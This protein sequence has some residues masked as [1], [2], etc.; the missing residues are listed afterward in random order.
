MGNEEEFRS[1]VI[2]EVA[3][4]A[5]ALLGTRQQIQPFSSQFPTFDLA[6]AYDV[7]ERIRTARM[8]RGEKPAGRKIGFTNRAT[9]ASF[10]I[11]A[12]IWGYVYDS[13][14]ADL[15]DNAASFSVAALPEAR[16]EPEIVLHLAR[17]PQLGMNER[18]LFGCIDWIAHGFEIVCSI[19]P[20]WRF[21]AA[22]AVA[23]FGMHSA[24]L[25][26]TRHEIARNR[27]VLLDSL[28]NFTIE[29]AGNSGTRRGH[30]QGILGGPLSA[31]RA[32]VDV[33]A[34]YPNSIPLEAGEVVTTGA[35]TEPMPLVA[36]EV[37]STQVFGIDLKGLRLLVE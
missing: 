24:L 23:A 29:L 34:Q 21:K 11:S 37:W 5:L 25:V 20:H 6:D 35:L 22:D 3:H 33:L 12:P 17:A 28:S 27:E 32:L 1:T 19:F 16:I 15:D 13:T 10:G 26:G 7:A 9:W 2:A 4:E 8:G 36:G 30:A 18:E 31:F 14:V